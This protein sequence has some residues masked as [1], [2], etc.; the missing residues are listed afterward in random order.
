MGKNYRNR[1]KTSATPRK[2]FEKERLDNEY[3]SILIKITNY[4]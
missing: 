2:P 1:S 4:W 3:I